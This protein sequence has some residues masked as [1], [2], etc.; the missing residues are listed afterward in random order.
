MPN[1]EKNHKVGDKNKV[2]MNPETREIHA[3]IPLSAYTKNDD[4]LNPTLNK[5]GQGIGTH[6]VDVNKQTDLELGALA[7]PGGIDPSTDQEFL[8]EMSQKVEEN[9]EG[10]KL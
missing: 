5:M 9:R 1:S 2:T 6:E 3:D 8:E 7:D 4:S 10:G